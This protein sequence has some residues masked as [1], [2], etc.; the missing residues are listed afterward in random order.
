MIVLLIN[1]R[2]MESTLSKYFAGEMTSEEKED[3]FKE[4]AND[5]ELQDNFL[6]YQNLLALVDWTYPK[7]KNNDELYQRKLIEFVQDKNR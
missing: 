6:E 5:S 4:V 7:T 2:R 3:F 1:S